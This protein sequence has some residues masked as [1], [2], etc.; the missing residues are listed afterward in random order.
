MLLERAGWTLD[1]VDT[2]V[3]HQANLFI[4]QHL[5]K[6]MGIPGDKLVENISGYGNTSGASIPLAMSQQLAPQLRA[7]PQ[8]LI[9]LGFGTG[10]SWGGVAMHC[11]PIVVPELS[12][13]SPGDKLHV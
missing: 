13:V 3:M 12:T 2:V 10:L 9:L 5:A 1:D 4:M 6:K 11:G 8:R 7:K